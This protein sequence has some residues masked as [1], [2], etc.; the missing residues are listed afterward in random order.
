MLRLCSSDFGCNTVLK[1]QI[2][3]K[4]STFGGFLLK[5]FSKLER[6]GQKVPG[7]SIITD[8]GT[9]PQGTA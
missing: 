7:L 2:C 4:K 6:T 8:A 1:L 9:P 3:P 5:I